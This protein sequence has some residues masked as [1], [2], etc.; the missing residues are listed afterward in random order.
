M[1]FDVY[2]IGVGPQFEG[3]RIRKKELIFELSGPKAK[4]FEVCLVKNMK[5]ILFFDAFRF[6]QREHFGNLIFRC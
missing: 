5:E 6:N 4:G 3:E 1:S 2:P